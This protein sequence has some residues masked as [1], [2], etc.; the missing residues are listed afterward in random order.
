MSSVHPSEHAEL[1]R[2]PDDVG[3]RFF[4]VDLHGEPLPPAHPQSADDAVLG[5]PV[6]QGNPAEVGDLH[7]VVDEA[8]R[9]RP[10]DRNSWRIAIIDAFH[11]AH[12]IPHPILL[13]KR[14]FPP[15]KCD[16]NRASSP[17]TSVSFFTFSRPVTPVHQVPAEP[18]TSLSAS[19]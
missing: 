8:D 10:R 12:G 19:R 13:L 14:A 15:V 5:R 16:R 17:V 11:E 1:L 9:A 18:D 6:G 7:I 4:V 2:L 3:S